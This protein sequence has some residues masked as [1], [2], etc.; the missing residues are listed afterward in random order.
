MNI[1]VKVV[2]FI[3]ATLVMTYGIVKLSQGKFNELN[4]PEVNWRQLGDLD[5]ISKT[6]PESLKP[7]DNKLVRIPGFMVPLEDN[8]SVV[9]EFLLVS[10][11]QAC[12]HVPPPPPN[13][14]IYVKAEEGKKIKSEFGPVWVH[15]VLNI[16]V[17]KHMYGE[18]SFQ[19]TAEKV[20]PYE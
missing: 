14:M 19:M 18:S 5:Y 9:T 2:I 1:F 11:P 4:G 12:I 3:F 13:Q 8:Q 16:S 20:E 17:K 15:G 6:I 10:N 7:F